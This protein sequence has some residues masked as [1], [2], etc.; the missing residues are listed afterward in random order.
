MEQRVYREYQLKF[1]LN[2]SHYI[3]IDG[4]RQQTHPHTWE[5]SLT[6]RIGRSTF[7]AFHT[8]ETEIEQ[9]LAP[10][11]K[12]ILNEVEPFD[13]IVP[14]LENMVDWFAQEFR[15]VVSEIG[16]RLVRLEASETPTRSYILEL[17]RLEKDEPDTASEEQMIDEIVDSVLSEILR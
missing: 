16:G 11:Q 17:D 8:F 4:D 6:I 13:Q 12:R 10:F 3:I 1:Y 9:I 2:A 14:T 15:R 7:K 5:F